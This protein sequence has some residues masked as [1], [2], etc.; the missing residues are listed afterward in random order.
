MSICPQCQASNKQESRFCK[1][2]GSPIPAKKQIPTEEPTPPP[3][4]QW[5]FKKLIT[6]ILKETFRSLI[7]S[8]PMSIL[9]FVLGI[10]LQIFIPLEG[11]ILGKLGNSIVGSLFWTFISGSFFILIGSFRKKG[12]FGTLKEFFCIPRDIIRYMWSTGIGSFIIIF[13]GI[14]LALTTGSMVQGSSSVLIA[15]GL[16]MTFSSAFGRGL[17]VLIQTTWG[18]ISQIRG[19]KDSNPQM[20]FGLAASYVVMIGSILGFIANSLFI[21]DSFIQLASGITLLVFS[22][23]LLSRKGHSQSAQALGIL[24]GGVGVY[25]CLEVIPTLAMSLGDIDKSLQVCQIGDPTCD[26]SAHTIPD[27]PTSPPQDDSSETVEYIWD[28]HDIPGYEEAIDTSVPTSAGGWSTLNN[29]ERICCSMNGCVFPEGSFDSRCSGGSSSG[30]FIDFENM[31]FLGSDLFSVPETVEQATE[32]AVYGTP[33][34]IGIAL[35]PLVGNALS[36]IGLSAGALPLSPPPTPPTDT[37]QGPEPRTPEEQA[38]YNA[39]RSLV[40][41]V[42]KIE[43]KTLRKLLLQK[44]KKAAQL[45]QR[46]VPC[47]DIKSIAEKTKQY[48]TRWNAKKQARQKDGLHEAIEKLKNI[49]VDVDTKNHLIKAVKK[50]SKIDKNL[51]P[52]GNMEQINRM[53]DAQIRAS[54]DKPGKSYWKEVGKNFSKNVVKDVKTLPDYVVD[55]TNTLIE[56]SK[57]VG[58]NIYREA[59]DIDN[60]TA[61]KTAAG[62]TLKDVLGSPIKSAKK[63]GNFYKTGAEKTGEILGNITAAIEKDPKILLEVGKNIIGLD[64]WEK[65]IDPNK[66][67]GDRIGNAIY[68]AV[69]TVLNFA[70]G[71]SAKAAKLDHITDTLKTVEKVDDVIDSGKITTTV[72]KTGEKMK[73]LSIAEKV[74]QKRK[75]IRKLDETEYDMLK[76][77]D[78]LAESEADLKIKSFE[79]ALKKGDSEATKRAALEIQRDP[80]AKQKCNIH[81]EITDSAGNITDRKFEVDETVRKGFKDEMNGIYHEVD[82][83]LTKG[84]RKQMTEN[85]K[86][87]KKDFGIDP[88]TVID[89]KFIEKIE[90]G[91]KEN[92]KE[93]KKEFSKKYGMDPEEVTDI[94]VQTLSGKREYVKVDA[95]RDAAVH[96]TVIDKDTGMLKKVEIADRKGVLQKQHDEI[97]YDKAGGEK[98][99]S[100]L[101]K[102]E[103]AEDMEQTIIHAK[104][105]EGFGKNAKQVL[106][107]D[108]RAEKDASAIKGAMEFKGTK[109]HN[110]ADDLFA[111]GNL[112]AASKSRGE[113][114][115]MT[116]K[117]SEIVQM[118]ID[119]VSDELTAM[120]KVAPKMPDR[121]QKGLDIM[122]EIGKPLKEGGKFSPADAEKALREIG[123]TSREVTSGVAETYES[124]YTLM[125]NK[126]KIFSSLQP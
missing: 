27:T 62:Q 47:G 104:H 120:G 35:G 110:E 32:R 23:I 18:T 5:T 1:K 67:L 116:V 96:V 102:S 103:F 15:L 84:L 121:I 100:H 14:G 122:K 75:M 71:G 60:Y 125:P 11:G 78:R 77:A 9:F 114:M 45:D 55:T 70:S 89:E 107:G 119:S 48:I 108:I 7:K 4:T 106:E 123:I 87:F 42:K 17:A 64:T 91:L 51:V 39:L 69:D 59:T 66:P 44:I 68:G 29:G 118:H 105:N 50:A 93:F 126:Q 22:F 79:R 90:T 117:E 20:N 3:T 38:S 52:H 28:T 95:D 83:E 54:Q 74:E 94:K 36:N 73:E 99:Y 101:S 124:L 49:D 25:H 56:T 31:T 82:H 115:R 57:K 61:L 24:F 21:Q 109:F 63:V 85:P 58:E 16:T 13:S 98:H 12:I 81:D 76:K 112:G 65:V 86:Q 30:N 97:F 41:K 80:L 10:L 33:S 72:A 92:P 88:D 26:P 113:A 43:D 2:C 40:S 53:L 6:H 34:G 46:R 8:I 111:S 37:P 19:K